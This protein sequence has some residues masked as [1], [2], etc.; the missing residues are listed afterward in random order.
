MKYLLILFLS[1]QILFAQDSAADS[2][3]M[4]YTIFQDGKA[5][6]IDSLT[7]A[8]AKAKVVFLGENHDDPIAH[9]LELELFVRL[10]AEH[11]GNINLAMEMFER[12]VQYVMDEYILKNMIREKDFLAA[13]RPWKNYETDY[14][15]LIEF[16]KLNKIRVFGSNAP[17]RY[18]SAVG[19]HGK[20]VLDLLNADGIKSLAPATYLA[21]GASQKYAAKFNDLMGDM[22]G[23]FNPNMLEAQNLRDATMAHTMIKI[24]AFDDITNFLH[25]NGSFHSEDRLGIPDYL[26]RYIPNVPY[27]VV[28]MI[29]EN[30]FKSFVPEKHAGK[31]DFV[32]LTNAKLPRTYEARF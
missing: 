26:N 10:F 9:K 25:I 31:G 24:L 27:S 20:Q 6:S 15:P 17:G 28:T 5:I 4:H 1:V 29:A 16:A 18:V 7:H 14:K 8:L 19:R 30:D 3:A 22:G 11:N 2:T 13:T 21:N 32:I 12:D 23:H